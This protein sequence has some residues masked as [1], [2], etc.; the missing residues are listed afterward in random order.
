MTPQT[1]IAHSSRWNRIATLPLLGVS[2]FFASLLLYKL[3][4]DGKGVHI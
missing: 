2:L 1:S 3:F 4:K